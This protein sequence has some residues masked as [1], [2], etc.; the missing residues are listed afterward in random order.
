MLEIF[1]A[2]K[3]Y[4]PVI[5]DTS[6][7]TS[8]LE[9]ILHYMV[10]KGNIN[11]QPLFSSSRMCQY[12]WSNMYLAVFMYTCKVLGTVSISHCG[13]I[14]SQSMIGIILLHTICMK[15]LWNEGEKSSTC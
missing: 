7:V 1:S 8:L 4:H 12:G 6:C 2:E 14:H 9:Q 15:T 10:Q 5:P 11:L 3:T 13:M